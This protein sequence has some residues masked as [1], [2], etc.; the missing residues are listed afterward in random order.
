MQHTSIIAILKK[1]KPEN[2]YGIVYIR[3]YYNS[4]PVAA[5][6]TGYKV[7]LCNWDAENRC[8]FDKAPNAKLVNSCITSKVA[9]MEKRLLQ[10]EIMGKSINRQHIKSAVK[11]H[12][13][14]KDFIKFCTKNIKQKYS[15]GE[16]IRTYTS[17][18]TK[19]QQ[20]KQEISFADLDF[21]FLTD[22][23]EFMRDKLNNADNTIWKSFKFI[24]TMTKD[25]LKQ[26]GI[27]VQDPFAEFDR[28]NYVQTD[29][30]YL[31]IDECEKIFAII[32]NEFVPADMRSVAIYFLLMC[33]SGLRY[34]DA[35]SFNPSMHVI[36]DERLV[37]KT[38]KGEGNIIN[39]K[40]YG[41]LREIVELV[42]QHPVKL[43]NKEFNGWLKL[44]AIHCCIN[45]HFTCHTGRHTFGSFLADINAP[46]ESAQKLLGHADIRAT[47]V[48]YHIKQK[49]ADDA[50]DKL[51]ML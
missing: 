13:A 10:I 44:I 42:K 14:G 6:S 29:R 35:I 8:F 34:E 9:E 5:I 37:R 18:L 27:M 40:L 12:D 30:V 41:R 2:N 28:G 49:N 48:Y 25:A 33:Y 36:E 51:N 1:K 31:T 16:T 17:E 23:K 19:M 15:N 38:S 20:F 22:Y 45:K 50:A 21:N 43:S 39:I 4:K 26:G 11:G 46:I 7:L 47:K 24:R 3:G 32:P